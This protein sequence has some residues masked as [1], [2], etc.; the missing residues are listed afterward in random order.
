MKFL[1]GCLL[2]AVLVGFYHNLLAQETSSAI[3]GRILAKVNAPAEASTVILLKYRDS[4]IVSSTVSDKNGRFQFSRLQ[5]D[6]YLLLVSAVGFDKVYAGPYHIPQNQTL[7]VADILLST[8]AK[9]IG[10]VAIVG[11][12]PEI[13]ASPGKIILNVQSS[14]TAAGKSAYDI[15]RQSPGVRLDN[16]NNISVVGHQTALVMIDGKPTN[17]RG[18]DL[19]SLLKSMQSSTIDYIELITSGSAKYD[20]S[21]GGIVNIVLKKGKNTGANATVTA[22]A[23]YGRYYKTNAGIVFN[24]RTD[25]F[26]IFGSYTFQDNKAFRNILSNR[27]I[28][29]EDVVSNYNVDYNNVQKTNSN[30]FNI[31]TDFYLSSTQTIG[32]LINGIIRTDNFAKDNDLHISNQGVLDS[33]IVAN[34][35]LNRHVSNINYNLNYNGKLD[36]AGKTLSADVNYTDYNRSSSEYITNNFY[37]ANGDVYREP[38][39]LQN[40]SPSEIHMWLSRV[41]FADPLSSKSKLEAGIK[42]SNVKS[43]NNLNFGPL[44]NGV[45]QSDP[46]FSDHFV[47]TENVNAAYVNYQNKFNKLRLT[48]ALRAEQTIARGNSVSLG[49]VVSSNYIDLF[50]QAL[51]SYSYDAKRDFS[52]SYNRGIRRPAYEELNPFLY[53]ID[54]YD[55]RAGNPNLKPE[56][57]NSVELSYTYDKSFV[58]TLYTSIL[59]DAYEFP[60][61]I[62]NDTTKVSINTPRNLGNIYNYGLRISAPATFTSWWNANFNVDASYQRYVSYPEYGYLDKGTQDII[63]STSQYFTITKTISADLF[64]RYESPTFYGINQYR[65][66]YLVNAGIGMQLFDNRGSLKLSAADIFNTLR[67]RSYTT[68]SNLDMSVTDKR[69]S[70]TL[71]LTFTYHFGKSGVRSTVH[72]TG[73]EDERNRRVGG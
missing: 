69:E 40:L 9:Q 67:D 6:T 72:R 15:L 60:F 38:L 20:A 4:S 11:K 13:E 7:T 70:Q 31:G 28:D 47:Y 17:L 54:L 49:Q 43:D 57:S 3:Q 56:Y 68:Y 16:S 2:S 32:F 37:D 62:Q 12:K 27:T 35:E 29:F 23:G 33:V 61:Y 64:G 10:E 63:L 22:A 52:L 8:T 1:V 18:E 51:L 46:R 30:N 19:A 41:D 45:Y 36:K 24:D 21:S 59:N 26:N 5:P 65:A 25:K 53:Y 55:Y 14:I 44:V 71:T 58:A 39:L 50:P 42:F 73:N 66:S 34:S 48:A